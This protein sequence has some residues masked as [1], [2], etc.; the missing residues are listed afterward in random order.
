MCMLTLTAMYG[1]QSKSNNLTAVSQ[2]GCQSGLALNPPCMLQAVVGYDIGVM[3]FF[4][5]IPPVLGYNNLRS[6]ILLYQQYARGFPVFRSE[7]A[8][9]QAHNGSQGDVLQ[10]CRSAVL[11]YGKKKKKFVPPIFLTPLFSL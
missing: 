7:K 5:P 3:T 10:A 4:S 1:R 2:I 6:A 8:G 9:L 11:S